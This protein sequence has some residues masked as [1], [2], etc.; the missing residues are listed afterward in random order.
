MTRRFLT[1]DKPLFPWFLLDTLLILT[2][3]K[4][5]K[6]GIIRKK[7]NIK[8]FASS[9]KKSMKCKFEILNGRP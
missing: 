4:I 6:I 7:L 8:F 2:K 5:S 1:L 9:L 3:R